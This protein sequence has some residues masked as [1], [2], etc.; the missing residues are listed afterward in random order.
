[1]RWFLAGN[2]CIVVLSQPKKKLNIVYNLVAHFGVQIHRLRGE[3]PV[4][5][6]RPRRGFSNL[7]VKPFA[8]KTEEL[9]NAVVTQWTLE[10]KQQISSPL[11]VSPSAKEHKSLAYVFGDWKQWDKDET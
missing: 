1:M 10:T 11:A 2:N 8:T 6:C 9:L 7:L 5:H 3:L 4:R